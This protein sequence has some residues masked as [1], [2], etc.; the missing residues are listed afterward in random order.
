MGNK[1]TQA[2]HALP[3]FVLFS[4]SFA[5]SFSFTLSP[6][7][8]LVSSVFFLFFLVGFSFSIFSDLELT[9]SGVALVPAGGEDMDPLNIGAEAG[10]GGG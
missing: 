3:V 10:G 4:L 7:A 1:L 9:T 6:S 2:S 8:G 5:L